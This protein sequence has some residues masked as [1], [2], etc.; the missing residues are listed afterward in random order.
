MS[1]ET[2]D[3]L[4]R[5][6]AAEAAT[7][8]SERIQ[9]VGRYRVVG[10]LG[11]GG[12]SVVYEGVDDVLGRLVAIK[13]LLRAGARVLREAQALARLAHPNVVAVYEIVEAEGEVFIVMERV[14][15][16]TLTTWVEE[17]A[18][19]R[20]ERLDALVQAGRGVAAIHAVGIIHRDLKPQNIM[21]GDDGRARVMDF[22]LARTADE[23][24]WDLEL[25]AGLV[26]AVGGLADPL[27]GTGEWIGTRGYMAPEQYRGHPV[28][29]RSDVFGFSVVAYEVLHGRRLFGGSEA[30]VMEATLSGR[31]EVPPGSDVPAWL[32]GV[33]RRGLAVEPDARWA[34]MN[35]LLEALERDPSARWRRVVRG[36]V[37]LVLA[38][39]IATGAAL[40]YLALAEQWAQERAERLASERL[41]AVEAAIAW[42]ESMGDRQTAEAAF[43]AFVLDPAHQGTRALSQAWL[44]RGSRLHD[45][46]V[47]AKAAYA[48]AYSL[49]HDPNDAIAALL[50]MAAIFRETWDGRALGRTLALLRARGVE[51]PELDEL[52]FEAALWQRDLPGAIES[53]GTSEGP[54]AAWRPMLEQLGH[55]RSY[56]DIVVGLSVLPTGLPA[57]V[58]I[59]GVDPYEVTLLD[60]QLLEV[61]RLSIEGSSLYLVPQ[62]TWA[63]AQR[64]GEVVLHDLLAGGEPSWR[65]LSSIS[66]SSAVAVDLRGDAAP[67]LLLSRAWPALGLRAID[68]RGGP[69]WIPHPA[70]DAVDASVES[71]AT[72]DLDGD[73]VD[74]LVAALGP[75][76]AFDLRV[77]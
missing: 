47:A 16:W 77:F 34:T 68:P 1:A 18:P 31:I 50:E 58:A 30:E 64:N 75:W 51:E 23:S 24:A 6:R 29:E 13:H 73:G 60:E 56:T 5:S 3:T 33:I 71:F 26:D 36:G 4:P 21:V 15:G 70:T 41:D 49:A 59:R 55:V 17:R 28:D 7:A 43:R 14:E 8:R 53:L 65:G 32:D 74:E 38:S 67:E 61:D 52:G 25:D 11:S 39:A 19:S 76:H 40:G 62:T 27:T 2:L 69:E 45:D 22:G 72:A 42:A 54:R 12:M 63:L 9:R 37:A 10:M 46:P 20:Q 66:V 57:R 44:H 48:E 35:A